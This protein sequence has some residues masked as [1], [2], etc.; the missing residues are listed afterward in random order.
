MKTLYIVGCRVCD[1][2]TARESGLCQKCEREQK[3][4][5]MR[6]IEVEGDK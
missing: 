1:W 2:P 5:P 4:K 6:P 3:S